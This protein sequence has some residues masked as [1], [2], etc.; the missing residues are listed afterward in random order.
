MELIVMYRLVEDDMTT[1]MRKLSCVAD[2]LRELGQPLQEMQ[3]V[4]KVQATFPEKFRIVRSVWA[5][6]P[7]DERTMD[8]NGNVFV[9]KRMWLSPMK[10][11]MAPAKPLQCVVTYEEEVV[12]ID[13]VAEFTMESATVL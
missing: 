9:Q 2:K 8:N 6:V 4:T 13:E 3:L 12:E 7:L 1:H 5:N 11:L 10:D